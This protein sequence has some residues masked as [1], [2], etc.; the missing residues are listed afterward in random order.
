MSPGALWAGPPLEQLHGDWQNY[1]QAAALAQKLAQ[2]RVP[3]DAAKADIADF[4]KT[5]GTHRQTDLLAF[6]AGLFSLMDQ[7]RYEV[8]QGL[9]RFGQRQ[10]SYAS[11]IR[12]EIDALHQAQDAD[13]PDP[14]KVKTLANRVYWDTRVFNSRT[15]MITYACFVPDKIEQR[16]FALA[17][18]T[19]GL[20]P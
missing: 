1:P 15:R 20:L 16:L 2:R 8:V 9:D 7:E 14:A 5:A 19:A 12:T 6:F 17:Q 11:E 10:K 3:L 18:T 4:A 13:H